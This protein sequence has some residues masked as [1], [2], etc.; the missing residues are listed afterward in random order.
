MMLGLTLPP[1]D[2][3]STAIEHVIN[4]IVIPCTLKNVKD[5]EKYIS[6]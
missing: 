6:F 3:E 5:C 1:W 4:L 2:E